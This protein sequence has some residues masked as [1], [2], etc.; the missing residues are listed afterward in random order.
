MENIFTISSF[1]SY[2][3]RSYLELGLFLLLIVIIGY[4]YLQLKKKN[5]YIQLI[6]DKLNI[7]DQ[8]LEKEELTKILSKCGG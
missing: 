7:Q 8:E 5:N 3:I 2:V 6:F 4:L 1:L